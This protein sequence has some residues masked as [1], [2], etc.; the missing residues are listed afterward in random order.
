MG[1]GRPSWWK[2]AFA[3][4]GMA[5]VGA[6]AGLLLIAS[7][8]VYTTTHQSASSDVS[9][10]TPIDGGSG[11]ALQ[12][13]IL[14]KFNQPMAHRTTEAAVQIAPP[15]TGRTPCKSKRFA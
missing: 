3:P 11:I 10:L 13:P 5:W 1:E 12:Q 6:T 4:P 9:Y 7:V 8:V 2:R 14:V 15:P